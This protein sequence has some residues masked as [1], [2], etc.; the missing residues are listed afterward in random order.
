MEQGTD[1]QLEK[2]IIAGPNDGITVVGGGNT[3]LAPDTEV[4]VKAIP[5]VEP[6]KV[7][8]AP[9]LRGGKKVDPL[10]PT[11]IQ[12]ETTAAVE[13][14][15]Q[16]PSSHFPPPD[17]SLFKQSRPR[18]SDQDA[19]LSKFMAKKF[20]DKLQTPEFAEF[21]IKLNNVLAANRL[22]YEQAIE[23]LQPEEI[24]L[25]WNHPKLSQD[26]IQ[27]IIL[28]S[29]YEV[30][31][32]GETIR[33]YID[34]DSLLGTGGFGTVYKTHYLTLSDFYSK[35]PQF[36]EGAIKCINEKFVGHDN[37]ASAFHREFFT[38]RSL[39][40]KNSTGLNKPL[41]IEETEDGHAIMITE[42]LHPLSD[43]DDVKLASSY[44]SLPLDESIDY[45]IDALEG[46]NNLHNAGF[47]CFGGF[48]CYSF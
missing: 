48:I 13:R 21:K 16:P 47:G 44:E 46:L 8:D 26:I 31:Q 41:V 20:M 40:N 19:S 23:L 24:H 22:K 12:T 18:L 42:Q 25:L 10:A 28:R 15:C 4:D 2:A 5:T 7:V 11:L 39:K 38:L 33:L 17:L 35:H 43:T 32:D 29:F 3:A 34:A 37:V 45:V 30:Q 36:K 9:L 27:N 14:T 6:T 1:E